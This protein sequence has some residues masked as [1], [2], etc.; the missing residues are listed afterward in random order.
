MKTVKVSAVI[1]QETKDKLDKL[2][3]Q[4]MTSVSKIVRAAIIEYLKEGVM[5]DRSHGITKE[6]LLEKIFDGNEQDLVVKIEAHWT[7][8]DWC[9]RVSAREGKGR[10]E[11]WLGMDAVRLLRRIA[12]EGEKIE[13]EDGY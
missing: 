6:E 2:A 13:R 1:Y 11:T 4:K 9:P 12:D 10:G 7:G 8:Q 5:L 3:E